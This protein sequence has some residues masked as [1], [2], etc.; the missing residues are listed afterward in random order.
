MLTSHPN[1]IIPPESHFFLW[2]HDKYINWNFERDFNKFIE[3]LYKSTKF[4]TWE[5]KR[6]EL[7][8]FLMCTKPE[9]YADLISQIYFL[10][11]LKHDKS[12]ILWG[13]KNS[14]WKEKLPQIIEVFPNAFFIH[15]VRDGR[16]VC[17]SYLKLNEKKL[18]NKYAPKLPS[19]IE[20]IATSWRD[21]VLYIEHFLTTGITKK[22]FKIKYEELVI[23][24]EQTLREIFTF[25]NMPYSDEPSNYYKINKEKK[26]EPELY[27]DWKQKITEKPDKL[28]IGKYKT[29]LSLEQ[30]AVFNKIAYE[31]LK[32]FDYS[33]DD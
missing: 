21:N 24:T 5:L 25:L 23:S 4:E 10:Y 26:F 14:L 3:D 31:Q 32:S 22:H 16:D 17:V 7:I 13:D 8:K 1:I 27:L 28:N 18:K 30:I 11:G 6:Q 19:E 2:L 12:V 20:E 15:I 9:T 33:I 29:E